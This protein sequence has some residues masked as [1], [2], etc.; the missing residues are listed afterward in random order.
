MCVAIVCSASNHSLLQ[1]CDWGLFGLK[2]KNLVNFVAEDIL[3]HM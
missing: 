3:S 1:M 2:C